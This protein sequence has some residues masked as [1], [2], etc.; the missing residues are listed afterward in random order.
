MLDEYRRLGA[1]LNA[2][3]TLA[4]V[5]RVAR[6]KLNI[7]GL[8]VWRE[9][10]RDIASEWTLLSYEG[11]YP[12]PRRHQGSWLLRDPFS[13]AI[14]YL[15][16]PMRGFVVRDAGSF[17]AFQRALHHRRDLG[18]TAVIQIVPQQLLLLRDNEQPALRSEQA[19]PALRISE[20]VEWSAVPLGILTEISALTSQV[21]GLKDRLDTAAARTD[22]RPAAGGLALGAFATAKAAEQSRFTN[23]ASMIQG[24][25]LRRLLARHPPPFTLQ[26]TPYTLHP[27]PYCT[28]PKPQTPN[29]AA[30]TPNVEAGRGRR[31]RRS[32][33]ATTPVNPLP[34]TLLHPGP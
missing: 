3:E 5:N 30:S 23:A 27:T 2:T 16:S 24:V 1:G 34:H 28:N 4:L 21:A 29:P 33:S 6:S 10:Q 7:E 17:Q 18:R 20:G 26:P 12:F 32:R 13:R 31:L 8:F 11:E 15:R 19:P 25:Y 22:A 9:K 14:L